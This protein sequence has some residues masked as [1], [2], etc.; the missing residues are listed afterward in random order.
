[1]N[2]ALEHVHPFG[3]LRGHQEHPVL[4]ANGLAAKRPM[5]HSSAK[6][7]LRGFVSRVCLG[8]IPQFFCLCR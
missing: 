5:H 6:L 4:Q 7:S 1:M 2:S 8:S 3:R